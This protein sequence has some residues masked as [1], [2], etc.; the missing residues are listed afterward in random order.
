M[1]HPAFDRAG[2]TP[3]Q[4]SAQ[5]MP[6]TA[7]RAFLENPRFMVRAEGS[8]FYD[9]EGRKLFDSLS[10]L[11]CTGLGHGRQEIAHAVATQMTTLDY[12]PP[13]QFAHPLSFQLAEKI[14]AVMPQGLDKI[15]FV[16][17]GSEAADTSLKMARAYWRILGQAEKTRFIGR[18]RGYH[19]VNFGGTSV[20]GMVG[21]RKLFGQG[22][23]ADHLPHTQIPENAFSI[24]QP[25]N[26]LHLAQELQNIINLHDASTIAAVIIEPMAGSGGVIPPPVGYLEKIRDICSQHRILLIFDEVITGFGRMGAWTGAD[27]FGVMPDMINFAKQVTNGTHPLGGVAVNSSIYDAFM[28]I[29]APHHAVEFPHGYTYSA[30]PVA[31]AAG[32]ASMDLLRQ[33]QAPERVTSLMPVFE[34]QVHSL[35][36]SPHLTDIRNSGLAAGFTLA[37]RDGD[38]LIRPLELSRYCWNNGIYLRFAGDNVVIAPPFRTTPAELDRLI[39]V[40]GDGLRAIS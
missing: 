6:F 35:K 1:S 40:L 34:R 28:A 10:G 3:S 23:E 20:G 21:N 4:A 19:G 26:G 15:F 32:I 18:V 37:P 14:V 7:N 31:C 11:W 29:K 16:G 36:G 38:A 39:N 22:V 30:H 12:S 9:A 25:Q 33:E 5:W 8:Y 2:I 24:G 17:S 13:F 27:A